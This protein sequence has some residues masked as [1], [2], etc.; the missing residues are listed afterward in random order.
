MILIQPGP[1]HYMENR[2][3]YK[4]ELERLQKVS[5]E[6]PSFNTSSDRSPPELP[7]KSNP[8][9]AYNLEYFDLQYRVKKSQEHIEKL[10]IMEVTIPAFN[11]KARR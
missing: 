3:A 1:G 6:K 2:N 4:A 7:S 8:L 9:C 10:K 11:T 5:P